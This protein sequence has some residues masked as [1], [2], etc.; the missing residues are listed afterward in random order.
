MKI[1]DG[2]SLT[3]MVMVLYLLLNMPDIGIL[4]LSGLAISMTLVRNSFAEN[5]LGNNPVKAGVFFKYVTT[6]AELDKL[7]IKTLVIY[8]IVYIMVEI[9]E[10]LFYNGITL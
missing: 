6:I 8:P 7:I 4:I 10:W 3:I 1:R 2:I 5:M 9:Y